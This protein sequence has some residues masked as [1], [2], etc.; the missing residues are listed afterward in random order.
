MSRFLVMKLHH[1]CLMLDLGKLSKSLICFQFKKSGT[2]FVNQST[3]P[4]LHL[5]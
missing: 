1:M 5:D 3:N 2:C 4:P